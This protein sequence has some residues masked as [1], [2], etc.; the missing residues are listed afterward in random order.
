MIVIHP[1]HRHLDIS[2][3]ITAESSLLHIASSRTRTRSLSFPSAIRQPLNYTPLNGGVLNRGL[4]QKS[5]VPLFRGKYSLFVGFKIK[6]QQIE[7]FSCVKTKTNSHF[8]VKC[9]AEKS[10]HSFSVYWMTY[11]ELN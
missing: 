4:F 11:L 2:R 8:A 3:V 9:F 10:S 7:A 1:P 6:P 5:L